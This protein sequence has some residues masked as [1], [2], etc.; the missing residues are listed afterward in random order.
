MKLLMILYLISSI[1]ISSV[2]SIKCWQGPSWG[3][4]NQRKILADNLENI[5]RQLTGNYPVGASSYRCMK[6]GDK[7]GNRYDF[8]VR[9]LSNSP[10]VYTMEDC[11]KFIKADI[12]ACPEGAY[13]EGPIWYHSSDPNEG[14]CS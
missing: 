1:T 14:D 4:A 11:V 5:C 8:N 13:T 12:A 6:G 2:F 9:N 10:Q 3:D 7:P